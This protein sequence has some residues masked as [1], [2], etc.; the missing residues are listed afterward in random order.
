MLGIVMRSE[1][2]LMGTEHDGAVPADLRQQRVRP[3]GDAAG[4]LESF[5]EVNPITILVTA[6]RGL[7]HGQSVGAEITPS[8]RSA[9]RSWPCSAR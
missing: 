4:W 3:T 1:Q 8:W 7:M 9:P 2:A 6:M 5:V